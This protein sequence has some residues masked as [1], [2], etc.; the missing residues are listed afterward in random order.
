MFGKQKTFKLITIRG[1]FNLD[2]FASQN[3]QIVDFNILASFLALKIFN[4]DVFGFGNL[5]IRDFNILDHPWMLKSLVSCLLTPNFQIKYLPKQSLLYGGL[6]DFT[7]V[8]WI[9]ENWSWKPRPRIMTA[10]V[11]CKK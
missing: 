8:P 11:G 6:T 4:L 5:Q 9:L 2:I 3:F 1:M 7:L 10:A